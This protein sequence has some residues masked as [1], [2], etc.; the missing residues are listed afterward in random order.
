VKQPILIWKREYHREVIA[1]VAVEHRNSY[2]LR[3][4]DG[5]EIFATL[6][7]KLRYETSNREDLPAVGDFVR[8]QE[9]VIEEVLP[10]RT[11]F[12]RK[13][14]GDAMEAQVIAANIDTVFVVTGLDGDFNLRRLE[15][16]FTTARASGAACAILLNK[17]D[18]CEDLVA[19]IKLVRAIAP[20]ADVVPI[21][22][23]HGD[24]IDALRPYLVPGETVAFVGSSGAG[25]STLINRLLGRERQMTGAVRETDSRGRHTTTHRELLETPSGA[26]LIDTPG[27]RQLQPWAGEDDVD[28]AF[29][30]I[31]ELAEGCRYRD[32]AHAGEEGCAVQAAIDDGSLDFDRFSNYRKMRKEAAYLDRQLDVRAQLD[33]KAKWKTIHKAMRNMDKRK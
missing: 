6:A 22:A 24:G 9:T 31:E 16:Y 19:K 32:C 30:D 26:L 25:K 4:E 28:G 23:L 29:P 8:V 14:A 27:L 21:S 11:V 5:A 1:R 10:R 18:L 12:L 2:A 17:A 33:L 7:G 15:R 20:G 13:A 3:C